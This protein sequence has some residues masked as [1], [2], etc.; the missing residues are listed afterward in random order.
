MVRDGVR[1]C[2]SHGEGWGVVSLEKESREKLEAGIKGMRGLEMDSC[3]VQIH[4]PQ[5]PWSLSQTLKN[6]L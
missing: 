6:S 2:L 1:W 5:M 3:L 4:R